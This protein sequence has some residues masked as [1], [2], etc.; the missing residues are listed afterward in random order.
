MGR[1]VRYHPVTATSKLYGESIKVTVS[2]NVALCI[3]VEIDRRF[4]GTSCLHHQGDDGDCNRLFNGAT[5]RETAIVDPSNMQPTYPLQKKT[6]YLSPW[7]ALDRLSSSTTL[8]RHRA[9]QTL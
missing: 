2:C 5:S 8:N 1:F 4:K 6:K 9:H 7:L 3:L